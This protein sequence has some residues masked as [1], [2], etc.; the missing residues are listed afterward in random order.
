MG[1][2][3]A[4]RGSYLKTQYAS[5]V[6]V[7]VKVSGSRDIMD[8][9]IRGT[10]ACMAFPMGIRKGIRTWKQVCVIRDGIR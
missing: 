7:T 8:Y 5:T 4:A 6:G 1:K 9:V 10:L 2:C 3:A